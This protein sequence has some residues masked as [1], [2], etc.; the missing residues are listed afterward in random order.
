MA[1]I[2]YK[3]VMFFDK[4]LLLECVALSFY[5]LPRISNTNY[6]ESV[7]NYNVVQ[8]PYNIVFHDCIKMSATTSRVCD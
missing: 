6:V 8:P 2:L 1:Q 4:K 5:L 3:V 7:Q